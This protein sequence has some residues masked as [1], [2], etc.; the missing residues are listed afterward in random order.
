MTIKFD[1]RPLA[2]EQ[3][4]YVTKIANAYIVYEL[5]TWPNIHGQI[6]KLLIWC[7]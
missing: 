3:K 6:K 7:D 1:K 5:Y 2:V 4:N